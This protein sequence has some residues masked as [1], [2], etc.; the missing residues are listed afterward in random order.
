MA[1]VRQTF[2]D[3]IVS[4][5]NGRDGEGEFLIRKCLIMQLASGCGDSLTNQLLS[6]KK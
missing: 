5:V 4:H 3:A 1:E 2:L 6:N